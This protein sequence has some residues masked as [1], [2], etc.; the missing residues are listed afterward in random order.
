MERALAVSS[1]DPAVVVIEARKAAQSS[2]AP[3][4]PIGVALVRF[5]RPPPSLDHYDSLLEVR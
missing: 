1:I 4:I 3:I 2:V 5:D